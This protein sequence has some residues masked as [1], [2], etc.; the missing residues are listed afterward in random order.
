VGSVP[1]AAEHETL[2]YF[3]IHPMN[4]I[5]D[6]QKLSRSFDNHWGEMLI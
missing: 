3:W 1:E 6:A 2:E 5:A 4:C